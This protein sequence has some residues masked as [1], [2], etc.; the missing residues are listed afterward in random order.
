M[1]IS[2][3]KK[4]KEAVKRMELMGIFPETIRQFK[5]YGYVSISEPPL[6]ALFWADG[7]ELEII[8]RFEAENNAVVYI[9]ILSF[10]NFGKMLSLLYVSDYESEWGLDVEYLKV[11]EAVAYV[12]NFDMPDCSESGFIGFRRSAAAGL[13]RTS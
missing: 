12:H 9:G 6:G 11:G 2:I 4:K 10:T 13:I 8:K 1:S 3:E 7:E 5:E